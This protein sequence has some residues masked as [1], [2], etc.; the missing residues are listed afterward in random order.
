[1]IRFTTGNLF[2]THVDA[3]VNT[4]NCVGVM[5]RGIAL[6]FKRLYPDNFKRYVNECKAK[7]I[8]PGKMFVYSTESLTQP[9]FIINFPT[10]RH[11]RTNSK[12]EY[13]QE[14]LQDLVQIIKKNHITSIAIPPLGC[15]LGGL[16]WKIVKTYIE[17]AL[18]PLQNVDITVFQPNDVLQLKTKTRNQASPSMTSSRAVLIALMQHYQ[19]TLLDPDLSLLELHKLLYFFQES[20]YSLNLKY[21]KAQYGPYADNLRH[22]LHNIEGYMI[23]GYADGGDQPN[24]RI[25]LLPDAYERA[26]DYIQKNKEL[27]IHIKRV[28]NLIQG[29]ESS[30]GLELLSTVYWILKHEEIDS[31]DDIYQYIYEWNDHKKMFSHHHIDR[32]YSTLVS[33]KW[34]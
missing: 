27:N 11:W 7:K 28:I 19:Q 29:F 15:G 1:M 10:K 6:Q 20:G 31:R 33:K 18:H 5:G 4:V 17:E 9:F 24:K 25:N 34:V 23:D 12:L 16:D 22:V 13:I 21:K 30:F 26:W 2:D 8:I 32:A 3:V 14:G